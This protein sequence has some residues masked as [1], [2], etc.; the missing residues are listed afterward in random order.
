MRRTRLGRPDALALAVAAV[1]LFGAALVL[2][3]QSAYG[4]MLSA[5][6]VHFVAVARNWLEGM[7]LSLSTAGIRRRGLRLLRFYTPSSVLAFSTRWRSSA[8]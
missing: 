2:Y 8:R 6:S 4:V 7:G 5:D 1:A 3:R